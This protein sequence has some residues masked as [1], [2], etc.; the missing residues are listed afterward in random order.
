MNGKRLARNIET[1]D[2][3]AEKLGVRRLSEFVCIPPD[4]ITELL[5]DTTDLE[6]KP[7]EQFSVEDGLATVRAL[8][9]QP[10]AQPVVDDLRDCERILTVAAEHGLGWHFQIDI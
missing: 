5:G 9:A 2:A 6:L 4:E 8:L 3:A 1:L 10:E 7:V